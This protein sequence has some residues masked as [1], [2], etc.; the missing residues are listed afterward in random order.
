MRRE[1]VD[2]SSRPVKSRCTLPINKAAVP[3]SFGDRRLSPIVRPEGLVQPVGAVMITGMVIW[4]RSE[5]SGG[6]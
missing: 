6:A 5:G 2:T 3:S 1:N 4:V